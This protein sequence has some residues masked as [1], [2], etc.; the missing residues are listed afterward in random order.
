MLDQA[1]IDN[2]RIVLANFLTEAQATLDQ[3]FILQT[4][5]A[6]LDAT[7]AALRSEKVQLLSQINALQNEKAQLQLQILQ[8]EAEVLRLQKIIDDL[9]P[10]TLPLVPFTFPP[11]L[12]NKGSWPESAGDH[13]VVGGVLITRVRQSAQATAR[14]VRR[15]FGLQK[16]G[17][18]SAIFQREPA[19]KLRR[20]EVKIHVP[21]DYKA[22]E[23]GMNNMFQAHTHSAQDPP[24]LSFFLWSTKSQWR[25][26]RPDGSRVDHGVK[27]IKFNHI[28]DVAVEAIWS[29]TANGLLRV[30]ED[31]VKVF[32]YAGATYSA[33]EAEP[34]YWLFG[35]YYPSVKVAFDNTISFSK[36]R[37]GDV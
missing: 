16:A 18:T 36:L 19:N 15:D 27:P 3:V 13:S 14:V 26:N 35:Q 34:P 11:L 23:V 8:L 37:M 6:T 33:A 30:W 2:T 32:D 10:P 5:V 24:Y 7:I 20:Y 17:T 25:H 21:A 12:L 22:G 1:M 9:S 28:Y 4:Q 31:G 29:K